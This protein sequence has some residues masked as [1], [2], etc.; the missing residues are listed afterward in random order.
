LQPDI[1]LAGQGIQNPGSITDAFSAEKKKK[2]EKMDGSMS[3]G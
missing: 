2:I 3:P 1:N